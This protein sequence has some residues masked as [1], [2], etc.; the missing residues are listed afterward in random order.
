MGKP[1]PGDVE[2]RLTDE[3]ERLKGLLGLDPLLRVA[4]TPNVNKGLSGEVKD[5]IIYIYEYDEEKAVETL[6]HE[7]ID[8][9]ISTK[10]I[11]PLINIIN[12]L[13]KSREREIYLEK[14]KLIERLTKLIP[15]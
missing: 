3:L 7:T 10:I 8:Y 1:S 13:I 5:C 2:A 11:K 9:L 14:E 12:L 6:Q 15:P 4:W